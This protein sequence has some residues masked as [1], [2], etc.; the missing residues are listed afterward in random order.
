MRSD[1]S[2]IVVRS[3][4][5]NLFMGFLDPKATAVEITRCIATRQHV[6]TLP[7]YLGVMAGVLRYVQTDE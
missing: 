2:V 7:S 6:V 4:F 5:A 1:V 3:L